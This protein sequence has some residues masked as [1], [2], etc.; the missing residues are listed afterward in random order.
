MAIQPTR[1]VTE[2][3]NT[4]GVVVPL[5]FNVEIPGN[6]ALTAIPRAPGSFGSPRELNSRVICYSTQSTSSDIGPYRSVSKGSFEV[7]TEMTSASES[8]EQIDDHFREVLFARIQ[9][10]NRPSCVTD[11]N[12]RIL[13]V[14]SLLNQE[15]PGNSELEPGQ[16]LV[17]RLKELFPSSLVQI[18]SVVADSL[19]GNEAATLS[20]N[21]ENGH[22]FQV[23]VMPDFHFADGRM[24]VWEFQDARQATQLARHEAHSE[25]MGAISRLAGGMAHEFNNL[26]TAILGNLELLRSTPQA[27]IESMMANVESAESAALRATHLI[28]ELRRF[29][30][31]Q[32][33]A[34]R[35]QPVAHVV[36]RARRILDEMSPAALQIDFEATQSGS[37]ATAHISED[38]LGEAL[39]RIGENAIEAM[40]GQAG[41]VT[42]RL[43]RLKNEVCISVT[44]TGTGM[45]VETVERAFEPFFSTK[46]PT[47]ASGL[48][49]SMAYSL[50]EQLGGTLQI[51]ESTYTGTRVAI[52][53]P[54]QESA[55]EPEQP[56]AQDR[57]SNAKQVVALVD[58]DP[59]IRSVGMAMLKHIG[60]EVVLF[61]SGAALLNA[62]DDDAVFDL[63]ILDNA[64]PGLSGRATWRQLTEREISIPVVICSG[65]LVDLGSFETPAGNVPAGYLPKP[66]SIAALDFCVAQYCG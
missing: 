30:S 47:R 28:D 14:N 65:R 20:L 22:H 42:L 62:V 4:P 61:D 49:M 50:I 25:K 13:L 52:L 51:E 37:E 1:H 35:I 34:C 46:D 23:I 48:G 45:S 26:L 59:G 9:Q 33:P 39:I 58:N 8:A 27:N 63:I 31:R 55:A 57:Q 10:S 7:N 54:L 60:H 19:T 56:A 21:N 29:A 17:V 53:L 2:E 24:R 18:D 41:N 40:T 36:Q 3:T 43:E 44:D 5:D 32:L 15:M 38:L 11:N 66:F 6:P 12:G 64:M 16:S